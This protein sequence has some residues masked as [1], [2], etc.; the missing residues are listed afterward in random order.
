V[1]Q[2]YTIIH[3]L[4]IRYHVSSYMLCICHSDTDGYMHMTCR[5]VNQPEP[6]LKG[7]SVTI[8]ATE[9]RI[10][11]MQREADQIWPPELAELMKV[12]LLYACHA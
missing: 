7:P 8:K 6:E 12:R 3:V 5:Y 4:Y 9:D 2:E 10:Q 1:N 11:Q